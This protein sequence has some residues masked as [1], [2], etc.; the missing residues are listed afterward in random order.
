MVISKMQWSEETINYFKFI[1]SYLTKEKTIEK[2]E[3]F[4][5]VDCI[6]PGELSEED[7]VEDLTNIIFK[8]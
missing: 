1:S 5:E 8:E 7:L 4:V 3:L 2:I 6:P